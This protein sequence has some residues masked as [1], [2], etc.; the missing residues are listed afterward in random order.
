MSS[1]VVMR[2]ANRQAGLTK[3]ATDN[4][5]EID[6]IAAPAASSSE[7]AHA[8]CHLPALKTLVLRGASA[9]ALLPALTADSSDR[10]DSSSNTVQQLVSLEVQ[11]TS[12]ITPNLIAALPASLTRLVLAATPLIPSVGMYPGNGVKITDSLSVSKHSTP[13]LALLTQ[14]QEL[15]LQGIGLDCSTTNGLADLFSDLTQLTSLSMN[16]QDAVEDMFIDASQSPKVAGFLSA[17]GC[18]TGLHSF[19]LIG[20]FNCI[21]PIELE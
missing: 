17:V 10:I 15:S 1:R 13:R 20:G 5:E 7:L 2:S 9:P 16:G 14:L 19:K 12:C 3:I 11:D 18:L 6:S 8:L 21:Q 4:G